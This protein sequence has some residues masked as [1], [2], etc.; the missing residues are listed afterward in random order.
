MDVIYLVEPAVRSFWEDPAEFDA[1]F[2]ETREDAQK[3]ADRINNITWLKEYNA[4]RRE[5]LALIDEL[6]EKNRRA[7][8]I[9]AALEAEGDVHREVTYPIV[10]VSSFERW[11]DTYAEKAA[12]VT[13]VKRG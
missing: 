13:E 12:R 9:N 5:H 2:F 6:E 11:Y 8:I 4:Y 3:A 10:P 7:R 1:V